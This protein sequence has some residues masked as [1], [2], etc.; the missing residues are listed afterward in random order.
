MFFIIFIA[1]QFLQIVLLPFVLVYLVMRKIKGKPV[2]GSFK[3]RLGIVPKIPQGKNSIWI[4]GV[5]VGEV[6][7]VQR[8][9]DEL[10]EKN[11]K[12]VVYVTTG[13][14]GGKKVAQQQLN[15]DFI[16]FIPF[17]FLLPMLVGYERIKPQSIIII[18]AELWPNLLMLAMLKNI[19]MFLLN[20]RV[21]K[22]SA[23]RMKRFRI[24]IRPL[25]NLFQH[26]FVQSEEDKNAFEQLGV[27]AKKMS[28]LGNL[29]AYN[30][31]VKREQVIKKLELSDNA[32]EK[33]KH[34]I[35]LV[36]SVHPGELQGYLDLFV[37]LKSEFN[38]LKLILA[39]RH[40]HWKKELLDMVA[41]TGMS[42]FM[43]DEQNNLSH[44]Q[45]TDV[46]AFTRRVF[47][48]HDI[49]LVCTLGKL[50]LLHQLAD[51]YFL[52]GTFVP[53][54]G[55]N[56]LEPAVWSNPTFVGPFYE[57]CTDIVQQLQKHDAVSLVQNVEQLRDKIH[58]Y[59]KHPD[60]RV[61]QGKRAFSWLEHEATRVEGKLSGLFENL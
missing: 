56:L 11:P 52:G 6:L 23:S 4:H 55:H 38:E 37:T 36:G 25:L 42:S 59:L 43:W 46:N 30:V 40:F 16:S 49:L 57:N 39:P 5:S 51:C 60:V 10:K 45:T 31:I 29:K 13:T 14:I 34:T 61:A 26:I 8:L 15:A 54:G 2:F 21:N 20:A 1:Y 48:D 58:F 28:V 9:I 33:K 24:F 44:D 27:V 18:E 41:A 19:P 32:H 50:F 47:Q 7:S 53:I 17:D 22:K 35:L 3:H 12:S